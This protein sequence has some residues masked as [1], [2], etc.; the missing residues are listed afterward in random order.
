MTVSLGWAGVRGDRAPRPLGEGWGRGCGGCIMASH[1][2]LRIVKV[3]VMLCASRKLSRAGCAPAGQLPFLACPRKGNSK[4][5]HPVRRSSSVM[6]TALRCSAGRAAHQLARS[7]AR[8]RAQTW[9]RLSSRPACATRRLSGAPKPSRWTRLWT[10][11]LVGIFTIINN[12]K[13]WITASGMPR[14]L[15]R[16]FLTAR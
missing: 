1:Q 3:T 9:A 11:F 8:P 7:A 12:S 10:C 16:R 6:R 14:V 2:L 13:L 5:G 15:F 4:E